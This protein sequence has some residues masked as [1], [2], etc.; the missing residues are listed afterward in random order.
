VHENE[1]EGDPLRRYLDS[2]ERMRPLPADSLVLP[3]HGRPFRGLHTRIAQ[4]K[5]HHDE[6][7][8]E[9]MQACATSPQSAADL[10]SVLFRRKLDLHQTTFAMGESIAHLH[11]LWHAGKL[12]RRVDA[13]GVHRF[14][15]A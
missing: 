6:R 4:L 15:P 3:S 7:L 8:A 11:F 10:L 2:L 12:V 1:P 14:A 9:V 13:A 5:D